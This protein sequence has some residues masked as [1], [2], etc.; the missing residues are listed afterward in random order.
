[1]RN[2]VTAGGH[3][4]SDEAPVAP[5][6]DDFGAHDGGDTGLDDP[7]QV[8]DPLGKCWRAHISLVA[9]RAEASQPLPFPDVGDPPQRQLT[10]QQFL[11]DL[12]IATRARKVA[13]IDELGDA[14]LREQTSELAQ[15]P[16]RVPD[17]EESVGTDDL[18]MLRVRTACGED[19][20]THFEMLLADVI[21]VRSIFAGN[22]YGEDEQFAL[23]PSK[24]P[25]LSRC[26]RANRV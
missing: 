6:P 8:R 21:H 19:R 25:Q 4:P 18:A 14:V 24:R 2:P 17:G 7:L 11:V 1:M 9:A 26:A 15:R 23:A 12:R 13:H 20:I 3:L 16:R 22:Q 5:E 10:F